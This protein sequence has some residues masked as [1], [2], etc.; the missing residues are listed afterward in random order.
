MSNKGKV[1]GT[2]AEAVKGTDI[3]IGVSAPG[4]LTQEMIHTMNPDPIVLAMANPT[5]EILPDEAAAA[6]AKIVAPGA[7]TSPTRSTTWSHSP[8]SSAGR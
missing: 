8:V 6:G 3:F 5:P 2:L 4:V 1:Q 7:P